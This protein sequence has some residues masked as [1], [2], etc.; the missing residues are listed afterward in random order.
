MGEVLSNLPRETFK[1]SPISLTIISVVVLLILPLIFL[2]RV[3]FLGHILLSFDLLLS[4]EPWRS[5]IPGAIAVPLWNERMAD[6][7]RSFFPIAKF[8]IESWQQGQIPYWYPYTAN[9]WPLLSTGFYQVFYPIN[10]LFGLLMPVQVA[11][12]WS[13]VFHLM[14]GSLLTYL[15]MQ[16]LGVGRFGRMV[17]AIVFIYNSSP[18][19]WLG[20]PNVVDT[21][22]WLPLIFWGYE[23]AIKRQSWRWTLLGVVGG[24][25]QISAGMIQ[26][27]MYGLTGFGLYVLFRG[28]FEGVQSRD[29]RV[30]ARHFAYGAI[31]GVFTCGLSAY[32]LLPLAELVGQTSRTE[33]VFEVYTPKI[34]LMQLLIPEFLGR[35]LDGPVQEGFLIEATFY[36]GLLTLFLLIAALF[37]PQRRKVWS[38]F[39]V[40]LLFVC[41]IYNIPPFFQLFY[42][43]YPTFQALGF[44]RSIYVITFVWAAV[45]GLGADWLLTA[46][47]LKVLQYL[48]WL[49]VGVGA[50]ILFIALG[51]AFI[52]KYQARHFWDIPPI[53][54]LNPNPFYFASTLLIFLVFLGA[55]LG[56]LWGWRSGKL[57]AGVFA[58]LALLILI[59]DLFLTHLDTVPALPALMS[60]PLTPSLS[61]LTQHVAQEQEPY[62]ISNIGQVLWPST[63]AA[64]DLPSVAAHSAFPL[65][66][67]EDYATATGVRDQTNF[68]V[69]TY[70]PRPSRLLD[71]LN[72]KYIYA[73]RAELTNAGWLSLTEDI[74][75]PQI[76]SE[77]PSAGHVEFW[78]IKNWTQ[79]V[80]QAP[81][82][83]VLSFL[84]SLPEVVTLETAMV[85]HPDDWDSEGVLF[86][87]YRGTPDSPRQHLV[88]SQ[89]LNP[90]DNPEHQGWVSTA[91]TLQ[92]TLGQPTLVSFVTQPQGEAGTLA[93]WADPLIRPGADFELLY[94]GPNNIYLNK[95]YLPRAWVVHE[96]VEVPLNETDVVLEYLQSSQFD[97]T[98]TAIVEGQLPA[99]LG[100]ADPADS[101]T[102]EAYHGSEIHLS[103]YLAE[104]GLVVLSDAYYPG[105]TAYIDDQKRPIY[106]TN[107]AMRGVF[108]EA[109]QHTLRFAYEP[110]SLRVGLGVSLGFLLILVAGVGGEVL[111]RRR[112]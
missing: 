18:I 22:I 39:A 105:W 37:S 6:S 2:W 94:Y 45:A 82:P 91:V 90:R 98:V 87:I 13:A 101:V 58:S 53:P 77:Q 32:Q 34:G 59:L 20:I 89:V 97:P 9:G 3:V 52:A 51:L 56:L 11:F 47:P 48:L 81:A 66:R 95:N 29:W 14:V 5:E 38:L 23:R 40:G 16:E 104:P 71:A 8:I 109:G 21:A 92:G 30:V 78:N 108:V 74:G 44:L 64:F 65:R 73:T 96:V 57:S 79:S 61:F 93:G 83:T 63:T 84:G 76:S 35:H 10:L 75:Q 80:L 4:Y 60:Y 111:Y 54:T 28:L 102:I 15:F 12:G 43:F 42:R 62:R 67:Y 50:I 68:R 31:I 7:V 69:V 26:L 24:V 112:N 103:T 19:L 27:V 70:Q 1:L 85:I 41:V 46:R 49:G 17:G 55:I 107:L 33:V 99:S 110:R 25:L 106:P 72:V 100:P 88:F 36:L 86:E